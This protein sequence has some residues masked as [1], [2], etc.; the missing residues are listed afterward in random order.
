LLQDFADIMGGICSNKNADGGQTKDEYKIKTLIDTEKKNINEKVDKQ[1]NST[2]SP[3]DHQDS[4]NKSMSS[5]DYPL[6]DAKTNNAK[7]SGD[8]PLD[9]SASNDTKG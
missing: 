2:V 1:N 6:V 5:D 4:E 8:P 7:E 3:N 9:K